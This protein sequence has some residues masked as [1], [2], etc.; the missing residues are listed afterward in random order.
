MGEHIRQTTLF[1]FYEV[2]ASTTTLS[3]EGSF[4]DKGV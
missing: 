4:P 2:M 3:Y 1:Q